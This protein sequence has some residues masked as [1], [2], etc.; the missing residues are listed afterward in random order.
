MESKVG[1]SKDTRVVDKFGGGKGQLGFVCAKCEIVDGK[2]NK[3]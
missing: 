1:K 3:E 2:G